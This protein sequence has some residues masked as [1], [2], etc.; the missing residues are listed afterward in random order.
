MCGTKPF[1]EA[2]MTESS[3]QRHGDIEK[4]EKIESTE[5][6]EATEKKQS[7]ARRS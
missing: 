6:A 1:G 4:T 3:L 7:R 5:G 2:C